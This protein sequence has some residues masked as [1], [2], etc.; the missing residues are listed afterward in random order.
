M[1]YQERLSRTMA[2]QCARFRNNDMNS[3]R[4]RGIAPR[5]SDR[6]LADH[7]N[8]SPSREHANFHLR[9]LERLTTRPDQI[10][11]L[12]QAILN[13]AVRGHLAQ[14]SNLP[15]PPRPLGEFVALQNGYAFKSE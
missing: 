6:H 13:L 10:A 3:L 5:D 14:T 1:S 4:R 2:L 7:G 11:R 8:N 9:H 15:G 12:R